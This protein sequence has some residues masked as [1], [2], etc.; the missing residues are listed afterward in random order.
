MYLTGRYHFR[1]RYSRRKTIEESLFDDKSSL[2]RIKL[3]RGLT[4][5]LLRF[6]D[7]EAGGSLSDDTLREQNIRVLDSIIEDVTSESG[8]GSQ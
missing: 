5:D 3:S 4:P 6:E 2:H 8:T 1:K 7:G